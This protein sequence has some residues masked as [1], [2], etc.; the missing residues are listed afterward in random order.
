MHSHPI[1]FLELLNGRY[2]YVVPRWQR[3]YRWGESEIARL[4]DDL[5]A[6]AQAGPA[7]GHYG[8]TLLTFPEPGV[9]PGTV[10]AIR[11]VDG[12]QRLTTVSILLACIA[13]RLGPD[14]SCDGWT[15][16][17]IHRDR[18]TNPDAPAVQ[19]R[20]LRLQDGDEEEYRDVVAGGP[21]GAG[22]VTQAW[23]TVRRLV[24]N[25][26]VS[27]LLRGL[28]QLRVVSIGLDAHEDPQQIFESLN[29]TGRPLAESEKVKNWLLMGLP[30]AKQQ[31]MHDGSWR[32]IERVL[33]AVNETSP[34]DEFLRDVLRWWT[35]RLQGI[36]TVYDVLRRLA[37]HRGLTD[38]P[39]L[40]R[41][42][43][44]LARLY[45]L[46]TGTAGPHPNPDVEVHL[47][48]LRAMGIH[49]HRPLSLRLL[50]DA[51]EDQSVSIGDLSEAVGLVSV[52]VTRLWLA[53]RPTAGLNKA[54]AELAYGAGPRDGEGFVAHWR[55]RINV[56]RS[57][58]AGVPDNDA[59]TE[60]VRT[61]R[62]YGGSA[63]PAAFAVLCAIMEAEQREEA[64][65]RGRLTME[66][67]MPQKLS[68]EWRE[69]LGADADGVHATYRDRLANLTLSG[70]AT[71]ASMGA[72]S[73]DDKA[74]VYRRS[75][76]GMT[77]EVANE[78]QWN[79]DALERRSGLLAT[80]ALAL[81]P[82]EEGQTSASEPLLRWRL[83]G[84][85]W[86]AEDAASSMVLNVASALIERDP[87]N[88]DR[89]S[90]EALSRDVQSANRFPAGSSRGGMTFRAVP[91]R[92]DLVMHPY[93]SD[94]PASAER[95][96]RMAAS[97]SV[98][99]EVELREDEGTS[100]AFWQ[101][102]KEHTGGLP[103]QTDGWR[104]ASQWTS[105]FNADGDRVAVYV[106]NPEL[107]WLYVRSGSSEDSEARNMR[108]KHYSSMIR[109]TMGDQRLS[110]DVDRNSRRGW[111]VTVERPWVR[112]D[113]D[114]W[115]E[116]ASWIKDQVDRLAA[117]LES[118]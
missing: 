26:D 95:C 98:L 42:L 12:Q 116:T 78:T 109:S 24:G 30:D 48:H 90:G 83:E 106:G 80:Q 91:G 93:D 9:T 75:S 68:G 38:R 13:E 61:R 71:N 102:L 107:L 113:R 108:M 43:E 4:V 49:V 23:R 29:A 103:G 46:L 14:G 31:E 40:C 66:H 105:R 99:I 79:E 27:D 92:D 67:V 57:G 15:A 10:T 19:L 89:L 8:G 2:Q 117:I 7:A 54:V 73:F 101:F 1:A 5:L 114:Q 16:E 111:S 115:P 82:W 63:T 64:P 100:A 65:A 110:G 22:A 104:G 51:E 3:R 47:R 20:K 87:A 56:L 11:V 70:D 41:D 88:A 25:S 81:W 96:R 28:G 39:K 69:Y 94:Y 35:G 18:L 86:N 37:V 72:K 36:D 53:G 45:G 85:D 59:V 32:E 6:V 60:G 17:T 55:G 62:A 76:I 52:W 84:G 118:G 112:E 97:C 34:V 50:A 77:R 44:A 33:G 21:G 58:R 74:V